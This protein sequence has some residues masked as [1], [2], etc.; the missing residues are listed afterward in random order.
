MVL[1]SG[2]GT[3]VEIKE[4]VKDG[5]MERTDEYKYLGWWFSEVN[6]M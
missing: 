3:I 4:S 1:K 6:N 2:N 5:I